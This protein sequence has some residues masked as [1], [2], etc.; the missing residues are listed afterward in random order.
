M[1]GTGWAGVFIAGRMLFFRIVFRGRT[2]ISAAYSVIGKHWR[3]LLV[4]FIPAGK[5]VV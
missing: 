2:F 5:L 4:K 3:L 1:T